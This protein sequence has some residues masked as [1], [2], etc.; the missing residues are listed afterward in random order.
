RC[1]SSRAMVR[2]FAAVAWS[3]SLAAAVAAQGPPANGP[4]EVDPGWHA[5][6]GATVVPAPGE[7]LPDATIVIREG[8]IVS[9]GTEAP[10]AGA[11]VHDCTGL[12]I[13]AAFVEPFVTVDVP[14]ADAGSAD[15]HW[16]PMVQ[17]QRSALDGSGIDA[18][19]REALRAL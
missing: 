9:V 14:A 10:P 19:D 1:V 17:A 11:R 12:V 8:R 3:S 2:R 16:S 13:H 5:L 15:A 18:A 6:A 7:R 4:R